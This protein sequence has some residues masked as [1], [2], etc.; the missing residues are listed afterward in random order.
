MID[1]S[2]DA[3][4][5]M[6]SEEF[7]NLRRTFDRLSAASDWERASL[8][9][10]IAQQDP[11]TAAELQ[12]MLD[13]H[14]RNT[15]LLDRPAAAWAH[16]ETPP[17]LETPLPLDGSQLGPYRLQRKLGTGG[18]GVVYLATRVDGSFRKQSPSKSSATIASTVSSS[19][20]SNRNARSW[21]N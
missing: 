12:R 11:N 1:Q 17:T 15:S 16:L 21:P 14:N 18:M 20:A 9:A 4:A 6:T 7:Q 10:Q 5:P 19:A 3:G 13:A 8:L 2:P